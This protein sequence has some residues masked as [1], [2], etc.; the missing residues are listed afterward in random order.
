LTAT[1]GKA[2]PAADVAQ[3]ARTIR[4]RLGTAWPYEPHFHHAGGG[5]MHYVDEGPR[6]APVLLCLHGNP[7]WGF[8]YRRLVAAFSGSYR[9]VVPDHLGCGL[10]E[11]PRGW[12]YDLCGHIDNLEHLVRSLDLGELTLILHDWGGAIGMGMAVRHP[13]RVARVVVLNSAAFPFSRMPW[14]IRVARAPLLGR[15]AVQGL[16]L[17]NRGAVRTAVARPL[18]GEAR[19]GYLAPYGSWAEREAVW[20][21]VEDI[22]MGVH[23]HSWP[24]LVEIADGLSR[25][26]SRPACLIWGERDW[27]FTPAFA[28]RW[29]EFWPRAEAEMIAGAGHWLTEDEP[30][31]V[32]ARLGSFLERHPLPS[33]APA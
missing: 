22:P 14:R 28:R 18:T 12:R 31:E 10:S 3:R 25:F 7:S 29:R 6:D 24:A 30:D 15:L 5:W 32:V 9:V 13:V 27:C 17:F 19:A 4:G 1:N 26:A 23:A 8:L 2:R 20:R 33:E 16:G 21:F 11:C